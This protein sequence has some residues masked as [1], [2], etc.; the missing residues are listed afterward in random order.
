MKK[1]NIVIFD[2]DGTLSGADSNTEFFKYCFRH[3]FRPWLYIPVILVAVMVSL[4]NP[5]GTWWRE[6]VRAFYTPKIIKKLAPGFI[7]RHRLMRFGWAAERVA[8]ERAAG[9]MVILISAGADFLIPKLVSDMDF[10]AVITSRTK[11]ARPNEFIFFCYAENKV[12]ALNNWAKKNKINPN[13]VRA[14]GDSRA[15]R[16]IMATAR[17]QVWINPNTGARI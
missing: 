4:F 12:A 5:N 11:P 3:S 13:V 6:A 9:N 2:F 17:E 14:Y 7:A 16:F 15:D 10:N 1:T 8:V